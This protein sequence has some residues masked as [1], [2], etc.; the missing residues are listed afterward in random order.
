MK[1]FSWLIRSDGFNSV[2]NNDEFLCQ[3]AE[4][5]EGEAAESDP[6]IYWTQ[7]VSALPACFFFLS[8]GIC[9]SV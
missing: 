1:T 4:Q 7:R 2:T 5:P 8:A 9:S 3:G 6:R